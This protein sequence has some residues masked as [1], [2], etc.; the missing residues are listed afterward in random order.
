MNP[1]GRLSRDLRELRWG[2]VFVEL[3]LLIVGI[4]IAL[5]VNG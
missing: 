4:L 1:V 2:Q 5:A 3:V